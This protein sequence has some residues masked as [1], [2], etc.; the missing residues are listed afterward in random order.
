MPIWIY[1][2]VSAVSL[3]VQNW[4]N[5][6]KPFSHHNPRHERRIEKRVERQ[7]RRVERHQHRH[8]SR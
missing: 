8:Q 3:L 7:E 4:L 2:V 1:I 5:H 6:H